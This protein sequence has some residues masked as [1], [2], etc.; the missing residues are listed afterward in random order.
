MRVNLRALFIPAVLLACCALLLSLAHQAPSSAEL[1]VMA[2][3]EEH[4]LR[5]YTYPESLVGLLERNPEAAGFVLDYPFREETDGGQ[6]SVDLSEGVP[7]FLQYD[8]R[9]GYLA[10]GDD[11][12]GVSGSDAMCLA[13]AGCYVSGGDQ[14]FTPAEMV[15]FAVKNGYD[16][17]EGGFD[18]YLFTKGGPVL[19]L[20]VTGISR[21]E[22]KVAAYLKNGDPI[23]ASVGEGG[24]A[25][26]RC[27]VLTA[28]EDGL[29]TVNDPGSRKN[30]ME[31]WVFEDIA[32]QLQNLWVI[33]KKA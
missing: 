22:K 9:W 32:G 12:V 21:V 19:G 1:Q 5:D 4:G 33:Q 31:Q 26:G 29:V 10:Y 24:F 28:Y 14:R 25:A 3:A 13:M 20:K 18:G 6:V 27:V 16:T 8:Q 23:I 7:L 17:G 11:F 30:S 15:E 2:Y